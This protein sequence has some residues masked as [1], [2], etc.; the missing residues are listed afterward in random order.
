MLLNLENPRELR[1]VE[2]I[3]R[4]EIISGIEKKEVKEAMKK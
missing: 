3:Q 1:A 2:A 4:Q